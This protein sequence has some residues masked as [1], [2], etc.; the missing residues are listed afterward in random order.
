MGIENVDALK[1]TFTVEQIPDGTYEVP[2][3]NGDGETIGLATATF[4][5]GTWG[6]SLNINA[7]AVAVLGI[8]LAFVHTST[9][10]VV[11]ARKRQE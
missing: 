10:T 9:T 1:P 4:K 3:I 11:V 5:D 6:T 8:D 2:L 7:D